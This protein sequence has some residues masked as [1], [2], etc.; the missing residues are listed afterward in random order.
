MQIFK[1]NINAFADVISHICNLRFST[2]IFP[3]SLMTA[4]VTCI[5]KRMH[6]NP[7]HFEN[8][9][10]ISVLCAFSKVLEKVASIRFLNH[11][12]SCNL[13]CPAQFEFGLST[14]D[15]VQK[16]VGS[17]YDAFDEGKVA[18]GVFLDLAKAFDSI[19]R[20]ITVR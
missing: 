11:L 8:Y 20:A 1:D 14:T 2:G 17:L 15:A 18:V 6:G 19:D 10:P 9:R 3:E 13:F 4:K 12:V 5:Y 7:M 16:V